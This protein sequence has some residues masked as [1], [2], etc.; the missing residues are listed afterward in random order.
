M[1]NL[2]LDLPHLVR[3]VVQALQQLHILLLKLMTTAQDRKGHMG[4]NAKL[5]KS[6]NKMKQL[7]MIYKR[8]WLSLEIA[9]HKIITLS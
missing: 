7:K 8:Q 2:V 9:L 3:H 5:V 6:N 4:C 1:H